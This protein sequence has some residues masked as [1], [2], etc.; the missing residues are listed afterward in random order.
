MASFASTNYSGMQTTGSQ[1]RL[2]DGIMRKLKQ[3]N[4]RNLIR[5]TQRNK[6]EF[7][8]VTAGISNCDP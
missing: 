1:T 8:Y 7:E 4:R 5:K 6:K 2:S 3:F